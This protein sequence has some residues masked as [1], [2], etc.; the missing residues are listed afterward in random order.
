MLFHNSLKIRLALSYALLFFISCLIIIFLCFYLVQNLLNN[1][2]DAN[3]ERINRSTL[4][5]YLLGKRIGTFNTLLHGE[6]Y[7]EKDRIILEKLYPGIR[8]LFVSCNTVSGTGG[9]EKN[10]YT[11][12]AQLNNEYCEVRIS[13]DGRVFRKKIYPEQNKHALLTHFSHLLLNRGKENFGITIFEKDNSVYLE[14]HPG[15]TPPEVLPLL[16]QD[17]KEQTLN[18]FRYALFPLAEGR[19]IV[20][21]IRLNRRFEYISNFRSVGIMLLVCMTVAGAFVAWLLTRRFIRGV[22]ETTLAMN[23]ITSGDYSYR[24]RATADHDL[25]IQEL[26]ETF[27]TMNERTENLLEELRTVSDNVAH[28]LRTPLTR[29]SG[30]VELMLTNKTLPEETRNDCVSIAEEITKLKELVNT[31]MDISRTNAAPETFQWSEFDLAAVTA[32]FC[33]FILV[34]FEEKSLDFHVDIPEE[35]IP[36]YGDKQMFQRLLSNLLGNALKFTEK[37]F[38]SL[39]VQQDHAAIRLLVTDS[40]CGIPQE[41]Q[42]KV[43]KRFFRSDVSRHLQGNGLGLSLVKAIVKAHKWQITLHSIPGEGSTFTVIIPVKEPIP[44]KNA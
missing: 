30:T 16:L 15:A 13:G 37:G 21:A 39:K 10:Y 24:L 29:I 36:V 38:V 12:F 1:I 22:K 23:R 33:E 26:A 20:T 31:I 14:S 8:I 42:S 18:R 25:E 44:R 28:D 34:A 43:F 7:P 19:K 2:C 11:A 4:E 32:D 6:H 41:D 5:I 3:L 17:G 40:G 35:R 27:N 9:K